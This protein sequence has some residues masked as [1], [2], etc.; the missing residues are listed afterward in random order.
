MLDHVANP[1][2]PLTK[3]A[4][5]TVPRC[6]VAL[7]GDI[8]QIIKRTLCKSIVVDFMVNLKKEMPLPFSFLSKRDVSFLFISNEEMP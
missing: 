8:T 4:E 7:S 2:Y 6:F 5:P 1:N 3:A